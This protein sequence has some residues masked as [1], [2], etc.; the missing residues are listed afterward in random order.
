[1]RRTSPPPRPAFLAALLLT[2][3]FPAGH[4]AMAQAGAPAQ[5]GT[6][7]QADA[8]AAPAKPAPA[9]DPAQTDAPAVVPPEFSDVARKAYAQGLKEARELIARGDYPAA[10]AQ[11]AALRA[12]RPREAQ[13]RFLAGV[14]ETERGETDAAIATFRALTEDYPELPEPY[15]NLAVLYAQKGDYNAARVA[16]ETALASAPDFAVAH[17]NL[18]DIYARLA[19]A[20]YDRAATLDRAGKTA[21]AKLALTR[22]LLAIGTK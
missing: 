7:A 13:A 8:P 20:N 4:D 18:G 22:Q 5:P 17:E 21:P 12:Q 19:A 2:L 9:G 3:L 1:V 14:V 6:P 15:N 11:I 10:A 16:L